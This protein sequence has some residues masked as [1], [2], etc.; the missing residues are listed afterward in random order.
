MRINLRIYTHDFTHTRYHT[1]WVHLLQ[2]GSV[3]PKLD[4]PAAPDV[5]GPRSKSPR[6]GWTWGPF[7]Y[8]PTPEPDSDGGSYNNVNASQVPYCL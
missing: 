1:R 6:G 8:P 5:D 4:R 7:A 3:R 2:W